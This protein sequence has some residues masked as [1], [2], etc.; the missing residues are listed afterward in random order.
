MRNWLMWTWRLRSPKIC[1]LQFRRPGKPVVQFSPNPKAWEPWEP[2]VWV[3]AQVWRPNNQEHR[4]PRAGKAGCPAP[5]ERVIL[6]FLC[7]FLPFR[8]SRDWMM[9]A[10]VDEG[11]SSSLNLPIWCWSRLL[12]TPSQ[13]H[14]EIMCYQLSGYPL[15]QGSWHIKLPSHIKKF[16][17]IT[18]LSLKIY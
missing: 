5:A 7:L 6:P 18:N 12:E 1:C 8:P 9:P 3:L 15:A 11:S 4:S 13:T 16:S 10:H 14:S 17:Q 2:V